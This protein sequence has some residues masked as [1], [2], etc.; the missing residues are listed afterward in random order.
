MGRTAFKHALY[1]KLPLIL[2]TIMVT[3]V[4]SIRLRCSSSPSLT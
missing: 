1:I 3:I 2:P 4:F